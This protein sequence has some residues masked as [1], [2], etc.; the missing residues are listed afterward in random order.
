MVDRGSGGEEWLM[1]EGEGSRGEGE[2]K[3]HGQ[4]RVRTITDFGGGT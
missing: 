2:G 1:W 4:G 3:R